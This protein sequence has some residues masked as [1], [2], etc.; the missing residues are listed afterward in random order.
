MT[1]NR[2]MALKRATLVD[3]RHLK[4]NDDKSNLNVSEMPLRAGRESVMVQEE[5]GLLSQ[6]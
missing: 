1:V 6:S 5:N 2:I 3:K 4:K